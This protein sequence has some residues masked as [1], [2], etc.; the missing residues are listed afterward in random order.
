MEHVGDAI[1][2]T[3]EETDAFLLG[4]QGPDVFFFSTL[5]PKQAPALGVGTRMHKTDPAELI[6][7]LRDAADTLS[8]EAAPIARAYIQGMLCHY[9]ADSTLHPFVYAQQYEIC[10]AGV[11]GLSRRDG[12]EVH[13]EIESELDVM[14]L[15]HRTD[16]TIAEMPPSQ[17]L[18]RGNDFTLASIS[19]MYK[20]AFSQLYGK[21]VPKDVFVHGVK[22]YRAIAR[23]LYSPKGVKRK[24]LGA[25][26]RRLRNHS[27]LQAMSHRNQLIYE[28][29][30]DNREHG[31]WIYPGFGEV[32]TESY[33]DLYDQAIE[34]ADKLV[35]I[36]LSA[37]RTTLD[38]EFRG[39]DFNGQPTGPF[40][41]NVETVDEE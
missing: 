14:M 15:S 18:L 37:D 41:M 33:W 39:L 9:L 40:V 5:S 20:R 29:A 17:N 23:A 27:I 36:V 19:A 28:S 35:P 22:S 38:T 4:N 13:A 30:F 11:D 25:I 10:D 31:E 34:R 32:R 12:H 7:A 3:R 1:G 16:R 8:P 21:K 2:D 24:L 26:E 6:C